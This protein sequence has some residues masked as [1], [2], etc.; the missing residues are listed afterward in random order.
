MSYF[1]F[2]ETSKIHLVDED[3]EFLFDTDA[4]DVIVV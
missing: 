4:D 1:R 2:I 3:N